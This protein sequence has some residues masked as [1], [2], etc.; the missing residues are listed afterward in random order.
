MNTDLAGKRC[1]R[2]FSFGNGK[3]QTDP[4]VGAYVS[5]NGYDLVGNSL[6]LEEL[7]GHKRAA[8]RVEKGNDVGILGGPILI[9]FPAESIVSA[10][11]YMFDTMPAPSFSFSP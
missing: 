8:R 5:G 4:A 6:L 7:F 9:T 2:P 1:L 11:S 10:M 3:P